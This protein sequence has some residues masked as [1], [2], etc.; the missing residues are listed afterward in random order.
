MS[1]SFDEI[2]LQYWFN[3]REFLR[4]KSFKCYHNGYV[5]GDAMKYD[6][7]AFVYSFE[8]TEI[9]ISEDSP[10]KAY[11][12]FVEAV[13]NQSVDCMQGFINAK[14]DKFKIFS[15][16]T[17]AKFTKQQRNSTRIKD[18]NSA[19]SVQGIKYYVANNLK[20][21]EFFNS[22]ADALT[23]EYRE[24]W[25]IRI[26][27]SEEK[28]NTPLKETDEIQVVEGRE[29]SNFKLLIE[30]DEVS[31]KK[32]VAAKKIVKSNK[33]DYLSLNEKK[34]N[35]GDLGEYIVIEHEK[36][37]LCDVGLEHL[38]EQI[39]HTSREIGDNEG[40]DIKSFTE[41]GQILYI[42]VK[43]T[44]QNQSGGFYISENEISVANEMQQKGQIYRIYRLYKINTRKGEAHLKIYTPPFNN[45]HYSIKPVSWYI[46][47]EI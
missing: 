36:K 29:Y 45:E 1:T 38:A 20:L 21:C 37:K 35:I 15:E 11:I 23:E 40:Y 41:D 13:C 42:E 28:R 30:D 7:V 14:A 17:V 46:E 18:E 33:T 26:T 9:V 3:N 2:S 27:F 6:R 19:I 47:N 31:T 34:K 10:R 4:S 24:K 39:E 8:N 12:K 5:Y 43:S 32:K 22:A 25:F 16:K 44:K